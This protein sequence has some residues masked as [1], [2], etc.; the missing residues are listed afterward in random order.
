MW[1][2]NEPVARAANKQDDCK[3]RFFEERFGCQRILDEA[4]LLACS[5][6]VDLNPIRALMAS[7]PE[8]CQFTSAA[9]RIRDWL[10]QHEEHD[11]RRQGTQALRPASGWLI[12]ISLRGDGYAGA[13]A[14]RRA[15]DDGL[16]DF[17]LDQYL[18]ILDWTGR[19]LRSDKRGAIPAELAAIL[20]RLGVR[21]QVW[22]DLIQNLNTRF[23]RAIGR[24]ESLTAAAR[25]CHQR[26]L[27]GQR[28]AR[29]AFN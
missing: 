20:E 29:A 17:D 19:E 13:A 18:Q 5:V 28:A 16:F 12:P 22:I 26:W 1:Y 14:G 6:Y 21:S 9:D 11:L 2:L 23:H 10:G 7:T 15:S 4:G 8:E 27:H 3:G 24:S 25:A